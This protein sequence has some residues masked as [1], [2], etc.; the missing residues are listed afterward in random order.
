MITIHKN[1][2][3][4]YFLK[5]FDRVTKIGKE[6]FNRW[7]DIPEYLQVEP[8]NTT[9]KSKIR[10]LKFDFVKRKDRATELQDTWEILGK[11]NEVIDYLNKQNG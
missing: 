2:I 4:R 7:I 8:I 1:E 10:R 11:L 9:K 3:A 5:D 6:K